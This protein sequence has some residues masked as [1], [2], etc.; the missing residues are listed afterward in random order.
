MSSRSRWETCSIGCAA[1]VLCTLAASEMA[2]QPSL[3]DPPPVEIK[4]LPRRF[5][6]DEWQ[7]WT[8]PFRAGTYN[9]H[10]IKKYVAPFALISGALI[11]TDRKTGQLLPK[12][13]LEADAC[14]R[15]ILLIRRFG[16]GEFLSWAL[17]TALRECPEPHIWL[18]NWVAIPTQ[19]R[20][21]CWGWKRWVT[22]R[23]PCSLS[24]KSQTGNALLTMT[25]EEA[26]GKEGTH[27]LPATPPVPLLLQLSSPT[28]I[29]TISPFQSAHTR[30]QP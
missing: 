25:G 4:T 24:S 8:S 20:R 14:T 3:S 28:R 6:A 17:G 2:A 21:A 9:S 15:I 27:S 19:R 7:I 30:L 1:L 16:V 18:G 10:A 29:A 26:F 5:V 13:V 11:A 23:L 12:W 22:H